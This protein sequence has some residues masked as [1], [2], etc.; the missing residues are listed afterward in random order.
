MR[1]TKRGRDVFSHFRKEQNGDMGKHARDVKETQMDPRLEIRPIRISDDTAM[2]TIIRTVMPEFRASGPGYSIN[3]AEVDMMTASYARPGATYFVVS[4][5]VRV[6]GGGGV[7]PLERGEPDTCEL[8]KMYFL[9][10]LRGRGAGK[11]LLE[12]CLTIARARLPSLLPRNTGAHDRGA[13]AL[14]ELWFPA[15]R[16]PAGQDRSL[17][18]RRVLRARPSL[19][20]NAKAGANRATRRRSKHSRM[21]RIMAGRT[22]HKRR[23]PIFLPPGG[24]RSYPMGRLAAIFKADNA[25]TGGAYSVSEWWL[26]ANTK[27]P[28]AHANDED[29]VLG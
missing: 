9:P 23:K 13:R 20:V 10:E 11:A 5:G 21:E 17:R 19:R 14:S 6:L 29:H 8:R 26:E 12:R 1:G 25:E 3:D 28:D 2:A 15:P 24:G 18:E 7:A 27:G 16:R 4:D 22:K